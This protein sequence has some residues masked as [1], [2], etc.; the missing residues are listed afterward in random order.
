MQNT[1][2]AW[3]IK[4]ENASLGYNN[5][6]I[7]HNITTVIPNGKITCV[8]GE[9]GSGKSTLLRHIIGLSKPISG[10]ILYGGQNLFSLPTKQF[11]RIR[12]RFGVL[13]QDGA[14]LGSLTLGENV[15]LPL[16]EN[17]KLNHKIIQKT[18]EQTLQLVGLKTFMN[19]YPAELSG[20]MKKRGGIARA[21]I[22]EPPILFCD[23]PTS[24]LDPINA[25]QMDQL[26]LNMKKQYPSMTLVIVSHDLA[27]VATIAD[28]VLFIKDGGIIF[29][30]SYPELKASTNTYL[31]DFI[32]RKP[33]E[34]HS[35]YGIKLQI[36]PSVRNALDTW[37]K[38]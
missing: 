9:S 19:F 16:Y 33:K 1:S 7:L 23:E 28:H 31:N 14:L 10:K 22:T 34:E 21:I 15:G 24:G 11:R 3:D 5:K 36:N 27:S 30:G 38:G 2:L 6:I 32:N 35:N 20:G 37:L 8:L 29:S 17:T 13:F 26:L 25:A 12:R 18:V 4:L